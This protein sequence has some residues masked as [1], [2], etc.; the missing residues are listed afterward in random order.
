MK[1]R[2]GREGNDAHNASVLADF[3]IHWR[4]TPPPPSWHQSET[5][6]NAGTSVLVLG[7]GGLGMAWLLRCW[8]RTKALSGC[9]VSIRLGFFCLL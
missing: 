3:G 4:S 1:G 2:R 5:P 8:H 9:S 7:Y 6:Q